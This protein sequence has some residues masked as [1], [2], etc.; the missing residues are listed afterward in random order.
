MNGSW[1][2]VA[3]RSSFF[4]G[5]P[6]TNK[7]ARKGQGPR[8]SKL[9]PRAS[10]FLGSSEPSPT[11]SPVSV[12]AAVRPSEPA[13]FPSTHPSFHSSTQFVQVRLRPIYP[14]STPR[15]RSPLCSPFPSAQRPAPPNPSPP[16][17]AQAHPPAPQSN[18]YSSLM[19]SLLA[20]HGSQPSRIPSQVDTS[21]PSVLPS[22][23]HVKRSFDRHIPPSPS[24]LGSFVPWALASSHSVRLCGVDL[25][26]PKPSQPQASHALGIV[27]RCSSRSCTV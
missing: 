8:Y 6:R 16:K 1:G 15:S 25:R 20:T 13:R 23:R 12:S 7:T 10:A 21:L 9:M 18:S 3:G 2:V 24:P 4:L 26:S 5:R 14:S 17:P 19:N 27:R 11:C 22:P